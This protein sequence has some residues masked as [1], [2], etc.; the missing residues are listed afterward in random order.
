MIKPNVTGV[1]LKENQGSL[2]GA[3]LGSKGWSKSALYF[4]SIGY[5]PFDGAG[6]LI[7]AFK[8]SYN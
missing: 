2:M 5:V 4:N 3:L 7:A 6:R 1:W 8:H